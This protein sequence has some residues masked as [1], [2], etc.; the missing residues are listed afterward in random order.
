MKKLT[1][2]LCLATILI[3]STLLAQKDTIWYDSNWGETER[4][5]ASYFRP[6]PDKKDNGYWWQDYY[7]DGNSLQ[8]EALSLSETEEIYDGKVTWYNTNGKVSQTIHYKNNV[9][10]G[11][12][13]NFFESG[14]LESEFSY[15]DGK[16]DGDY[17]AYY[18]NNQIS[19]IGKYRRGNRIGNWKE[20]YKNGKLKAEGK[21]TVGT[22]TG[23]WQ[24][25]YYDG[26]V[27]E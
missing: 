16:I 27:A 2:L 24:V 13:K 9:Q 17:V 26:K 7:V 10:H 25:Y 12:R 6:A 3:S 11:L 20:Y 14:A 18:E 4:A 22:K 15:N 19:E 5:Q 8:M 21:Y 1:T 23:T